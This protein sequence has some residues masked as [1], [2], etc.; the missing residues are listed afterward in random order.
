MRSRERREW[1][2]EIPEPRIVEESRVVDLRGGQL[3]T[4]L[5]P[6]VK[7]LQEKRV[8]RSL[9]LP[10]LEQ[11]KQLRVVDLDWTGVTRSWTSKDR[12][13]RFL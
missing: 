11:P 10:K 4:D 2:V 7:A 13:L 6:R 3:S 12:T 5:S 9:R 8:H 1:N